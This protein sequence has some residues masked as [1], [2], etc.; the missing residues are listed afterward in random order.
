[1]AETRTRTRRGRSGKTTRERPQAPAFISRTIPH[2]ELLSEDGLDAVDHHADRILD[3]QGIEIR[4]DEEALSLF[5]AAGARR[6][7]DRLRFEPGLV[8]VKADEVTYEEALEGRE[9][10]VHILTD[11]GVEELDIPTLLSLPKWSSVT[12]LY[13]EEGPVV[14][15]LETCQRFRDTIPLDDASIGTAGM[16]ENSGLITLPLNLFSGKM[17]TLLIASL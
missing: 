17:L 14:I 1:M 8:R 15:G 16:W 10:L 5:Q 6:E 7:G 9:R 4:G 12:K 2:Y 3:E 11:A 13:G